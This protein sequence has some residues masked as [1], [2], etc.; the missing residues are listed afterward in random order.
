MGLTV[1]GGVET[2]GGR[3]EMSD[4]AALRVRVLGP[5]TVTRAGVTV[6]LPRS[7]KVLVLLAFLALAPGPV[8]RSRL[9]DLLWDVPNDPRGELRWCL[10]KLRSVLDTD[11]KRRVVTSGDNLI[12]LDLSDC[13]VD[14]IEIDR[15]VKGG[16]DGLARERLAELCDLFGGDLLDGINIDG[17]VELTGWLSAQ[18]HRYRAAHVAVLHELATRSQLGSDEMFRR[19]DAWLQ[20]APFDQRAH[21]VMLDALVTCGRVR[22]AEEHL[23]VTMRSFEC[24]GLDWAPLRESWE[25]ARGPRTEGGRIES[26]SAPASPAPSPG[27]REASERREPSERREASEQRDER[28]RRRASVAVMPFVDRSRTAAGERRVVDGLTDDII[29]RLAKLRVLFVI[30][31]GSVYS[32][33]ERGVGAMEA[34]RILNVAYV[35]SGSIRIEGGRISVLVELAETESARIVWTDEIDGVADETFAVLDT[36][37]DRVVASIAEEIETAEC[38]RAILKPPCSLDAWEAY[39][40]GLWHMYKFNGPDN[41][42]AEQFFRAAVKLDPT[43]ARAY[44]GLSFTHFQNAFLDLTTDR[45][46]QIELA[47]ETAGQSIDADVRDPGAHWAMGRALWLRGEQKD[48]FAELE[49]CIELSPNFALGHYT[50]G[51]VHSQTGDPRSA[52]DATNYSRQLSPFDPL[53]FAMLASRALA[54]VR[55]GELEEAADWAIKATGRPNAHVHIL[56]IA[57]ECALLA[58][59]REEARK[60]AARIRERVPSYSVEDFLRAFRFDPDTTSLLRRSARQIGFDGPVTSAPSRK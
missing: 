24:E 14:A 52:I 32:L 16:L 30:A 2:T 55:L 31:R 40:R 48:S 6:A 43:F 11:D 59:R 22:D 46:R 57:V 38:N 13:C 49:H 5:V 3:L 12:A 27:E 23:A 21:Q 50:L 9:C 34:G 8:S 18:R 37:V 51:F 20:L 15:A 4:A 41:R 56:A 33:C 26:S 36:I 35:V 10:S 25:K 1:E 53:Q 19:L 45:D 42:H 39:H 60:F 54:H 44:A 58:N 28:P 17:S 7:R 29:T 47:F